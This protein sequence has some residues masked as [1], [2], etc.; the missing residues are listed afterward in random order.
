MIKIFLHT[1]GC[2][3]NIADS[4][5]MLNQLQLNNFKISNSP[6]DAN[7]V[8]VNTCG[9]INDAKEESLE[10]IF[11]M[12]SLKQSGKLEKIYVTGCLS[13]RYRSDL[14]KN[15]PEV[16]GF[17]GVYELEAVLKK[18]NGKSFSKELYKHSLITPNHYAYVKIS[19]GCNHRCSFCSIPS[20]KGKY[21]SKKI[22]SIIKEME[23]MP[24]TVKEINL[25]AQ[26]ITYY[27]K[28]LYGK[29]SLAELLKKISKSRYKGWIRLLYAY[30][31]RFPLEILDIILENKNFCNYLDIP[32]QHI[33]DVVLKSMRR[34][35]TRK[36]TELLIEKIR[37]RVPGIS[38]R[39]SLIVGYPAE[40][41][42]EFK[43]LLSFVKEI[44]FDRLG[45]FT[46]SGEEG[47]QSF[48]LLD[49]ISQKEKEN[50]KSIIL[51]AQREI[52]YE[53]NS[54]KV[55]KYFDVLIDE[56]DS[57]FYIARSEF[58]APDIDNLV[59]IKKQKNNKSNIG[60]L[61]NV[62][63]TGYS[64]FDLYAAISEPK[65]LS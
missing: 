10:Y 48:S 25:V 28:D 49:K 7:V 33:S 42:K 38:L 34:G 29:N 56:E 36:N 46:Y 5:I 31:S 21:K 43:E 41:K 16:D 18:L 62:K 35:I 24:V 20:F 51:E 53:Y 8:I 58:D 40:T 54:K 57:E 4:E 12:I 3:K 63:I 23:N 6:Q 32:I 27:G 59:W 19:D 15:I 13:E 60:D 50:R 44:K 47:T 45:V 2:P 64:D 1:L 22:S 26:D 52:S 11:D 39:T 9:F 65:R 17:F 61:V 37:Q 30:P 55:G 14:K